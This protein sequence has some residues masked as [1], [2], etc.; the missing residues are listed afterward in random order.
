M[1]QEY[2]PLFEPQG[3]G[4][5][6]AQLAEIEA[7]TARFMSGNSLSPRH[8]LMTRVYLSDAANCQPELENHKLTREVLNAG[9]VSYVEQPPLSG[10]KVAL[11]QWWIGDDDLQKSG[12]PDRLVARLGALAFYFQSVRFAGGV[13]EDTTPDAQMRSAFLQHQ[14][15]LDTYGLNV[16]DHCHRT[17]IFVRDVDREYAAVVKSRNEYFSEIGLT[18]DTHFISSTGIGGASFDTSAAVAADFFA[19]SGVPETGVKYLQSLDHLNHTHEYGVAFERGTALDLPLGRHLLISGTASIDR[20]GQ[21]LYRGDA[22][23]QTER[24][25]ENIDALL[26]DGGASL[27]DMQYM[28]CY[29]RDLADYP[30][31]KACLQK[32]LPGVPCLMTLARVCRPEWLVEIEG[33]AVRR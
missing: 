33:I 21:C 32:L 15:W 11:Q 1:I 6:Q 24:L 20:Y 27:A 19:V 13:G 31:V 5:L 4:S 3:G 9:F 18:K 10:C 25:V 29:L 26:R 2:F 22:V 23:R 17:W 14:A 8:L 16:A 30:A 7:Q 12:T 28:V